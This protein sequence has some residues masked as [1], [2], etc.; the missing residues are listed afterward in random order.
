MDNKAFVMYADILPRIDKLSREQMGDL[1]RSILTYVDTG[2]ESEMDDITEMAFGFIRD[3]IDRDQAKYQE[4]CN[5]RKEAARKRWDANASFALQTDANECKAMHPE[6]EQEPDPEPEPEPDINNKKSRTK[7]AAFVPPSIDDIR[8]YEAEKGYT[9]SEA[10]TIFNFY[11]SKGWMVGKN[12][13]TSWRSAVSGWHTRDKNRASPK[14]SFT[15]MTGRNNTDK[16][17]EL[18]AALLGRATG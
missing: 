13:M 4:T 12:K 2:E 9:P 14:R 6:P 16:Y 5:R 7:R 8:Q 10:E 11:N 3:Q 1:F 18:E 15:A 17:A